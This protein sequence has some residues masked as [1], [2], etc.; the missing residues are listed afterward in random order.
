MVRLGG[1]MMRH[2]DAVRTIFDLAPERVAELDRLAYRDGTSRAAQLRMA[3]DGYLSLRQRSGLHVSHGAWTDADDG[4]AW[5]R[6][7][8]SELD[9]R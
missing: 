7:L 3:V 5:Q 6:R 2:H 9:A 8:R 4:L 1:I